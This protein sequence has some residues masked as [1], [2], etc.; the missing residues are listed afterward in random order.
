MT[1]LRSLAMDFASVRAA[2]SGNADPTEIVAESRRRIAV[3]HAGTFTAL[4]LP[5]LA[6]D[7]AQAAVDRA[8]GTTCPFSDCPRLMREHDL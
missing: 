1:S 7:R 4:A 3:A 2:P 6:I 8:R 5:T